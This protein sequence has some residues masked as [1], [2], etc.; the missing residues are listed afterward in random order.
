MVFG[1]SAAIPPGAIATLDSV[2][3]TVYQFA[4]LTREDT[5]RKVARSIV[6]GGAVCRR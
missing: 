3:G 6:L 2:T 1:G 4:G 5:A